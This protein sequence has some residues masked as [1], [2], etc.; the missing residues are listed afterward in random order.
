MV[1][2]GVMNYVVPDSS[3]YSAEVDELHCQFPTQ[4]L[5][6]NQYQQLR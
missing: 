2:L 3:Y 1:K 6:S 4:T 5:A